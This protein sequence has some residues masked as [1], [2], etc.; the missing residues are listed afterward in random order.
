MVIV[1]GQ[2]SWEEDAI[3]QPS[4]NTD[5]WLV[6]HAAV[7][8]KGCKTRMGMVRRY[9]IL[10]ISECLTTIKQKLLLKVVFSPECWRVFHSL[11]AFSVEKLNPHRLLLSSLS[12]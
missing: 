12:Q 11:A 5:V 10:Y 9:F 3:A 7:L 8:D 1:R 6:T 2:D 4:V